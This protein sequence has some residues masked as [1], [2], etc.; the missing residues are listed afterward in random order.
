MAEEVATVKKGGMSKKTKNI[1]IIAVIIIILIAIVITYMWYD[2]QQQ[3]KG[4]PTKPD[5]LTSGQQ[6]NNNGVLTTVV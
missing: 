1:L 4:K 5:G 3:L 6:W 2:K